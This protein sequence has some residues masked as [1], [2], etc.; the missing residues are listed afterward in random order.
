MLLNGG[1]FNN[2]RILSK[3]T[4]ELMTRNNIGGSEVWDRKDKFGLGFEIIG[5]Q[6]TYADLASPG[7][8]GWGGAYTSD[9]LID[10][11]EEIVLQLFT[12]I[13]PYAYGGEFNRK[14]KILIYQALE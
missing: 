1:T 13:L 12:N 3:H 8:F 10:P 14:L 2:K 6:S 5:E 9:Y 4:I 11:K 7:S